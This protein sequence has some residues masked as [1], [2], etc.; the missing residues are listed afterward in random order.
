MAEFKVVEHFV[1]INGE[2]QHAGQ[3]AFF[4]RLQGCNL[5]CSYCDTMWANQRAVNYTVMSEEEITQLF[6]S[7]NV[8]N[9]TITGGEPLYRKDMAILL[10]RLAKDCPKDTV[11]EIETNGSIDLSDYY[12]IADNIIFTMDYKLPGSGMEQNMC[13]KNFS[14]LQKKDTVKFVIS[15]QMDLYAAKEIMTGYHLT[16]TTTVYFSPVFGKIEPKDMVA[17]MINENLNKVNLQ[18]QMHKFIWDPDQKGV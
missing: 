4:L 16:E 17:F 18:L 6:L 2:G 15:S 14:L 10:D 11:I 3:L 1:S 13:H 5:S 8:N 9:I 12:H 7:K